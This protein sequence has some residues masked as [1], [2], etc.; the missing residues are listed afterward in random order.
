M[1]VILLTW[2]KNYHPTSHPSFEIKYIPL[3]KSEFLQNLQEKCY[4]EKGSNLIFIFTSQIAAQAFINIQ[5]TPLTRPIQYICV[6]N[7]ANKL[8]SNESIGSCLFVANTASELCEEFI[9]KVSGNYCFLCGKIRSAFIEDFFKHSSACKSSK[10]AV[11]E[12]YNTSPIHTKEQLRQIFDD[13]DL[14]PNDWIVIFSPRGVDILE[15][16]GLIQNCKYKIAAIGA[17]TAQYLKSK[18]KILPLVT[19]QAP[20][21]EAALNAILEHKD[22]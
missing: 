5:S 8:L 13:H 22:E 21:V 17:T 15:S 19:N 20:S 10:L 9:A 7:S 14:K 18:F 11:F 3:L 2:Q 16:S 4:D 12:C 6:G 1:K